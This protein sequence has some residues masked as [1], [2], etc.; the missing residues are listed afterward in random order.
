M[1]APRDQREHRIH[2]EAEGH[3]ARTEIVPFTRD[4]TVSVA[5]QP[6]PSD[7]GTADAGK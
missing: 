7:R 5:L 3:I 4:L 6:L 2:V 1:T